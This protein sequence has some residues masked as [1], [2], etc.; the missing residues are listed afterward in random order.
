MSMST[1]SKKAETK[2]LLIQAFLSLTPKQRQEV[3]EML[4][5]RQEQGGDS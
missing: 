2:D 4:R 3:L 1:D 5:R